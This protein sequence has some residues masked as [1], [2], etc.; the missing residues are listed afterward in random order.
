MMVPGSRGSGDSFSCGTPL[1]P[2]HILAVFREWRE[3]EKAR[4]HRQSFGAPPYLD[5]NTYPHNS[6]PQGNTTHAL[7]AREALVQSAP[8]PQIDMYIHVVLASNESTLV[9][10]SMVDQQYTVLRD[11]YAKQGFD[12]KLKNVSYTIH[13]EWAHDKDD[14]AMKKALRVGSYRDY[15]LYVQ[16]SLVSGSLGFCTVV[17]DAPPGADF[18]QDGCNVAAAALPGGAAMYYNTGKTAVHETGHW[19]GL[20]H[21]F[22]GNNC[23]GSGDFVGDTRAQKD[24][25]LGCPK[26]KNSCPELGNGTDPADNYMDYSWDAW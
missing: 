23:T 22:E 14:E 26:V 20:L 13:D 8:N 7:N 9:N 15:N 11:V 6:V 3:E 4:E 19:H 18:S 5:D 12:F 17:Y 1:P 16:A 2:P 25:T 24:P 10:S 21:T